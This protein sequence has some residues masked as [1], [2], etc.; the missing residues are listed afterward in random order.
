LSQSVAGGGPGNLW[1]FPHF[2]NLYGRCFLALTLSGVFGF[3]R[4][5][6]S[7]FVSRILLGLTILIVGFA[8]V[9]RHYFTP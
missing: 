2:G 5:W 9:L 4:F 1:R 6:E 3:R 7:E 8:F